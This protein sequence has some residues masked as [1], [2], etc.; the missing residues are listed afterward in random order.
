MIKNLNPSNS[1]YN[2]FFGGNKPESTE[3]NETLSTGD[4]KRDDL[5]T[6]STK[7]SE[8]MLIVFLVTLIV[9]SIHVTS[10]LNSDFEKLTKKETPTQEDIAKIKEVSKEIKD[11][12]YAIA[13]TLSLLISSKLEFLSSVN[14]KF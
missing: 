2:N 9:I 3:D 14:S 5:S 4:G 10:L 8:L 11:C 13:F 6:W 1:N 7:L 12:G